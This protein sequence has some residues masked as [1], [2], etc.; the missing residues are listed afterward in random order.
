MR[1]LRPQNAFDGYVAEA[2]RA[3]REVLV[4]HD[5]LGLSQDEIHAASAALSSRSSPA[6]PRDIRFQAAVTRLSQKGTS[7]EAARAALQE[8]MNAEQECDQALWERDCHRRVCL[9]HKGLRLP[10]P[11]AHGPAAKPKL[12]AGH[13]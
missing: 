10:H 3:Y 12:P 7:A 2:F 8:L 13:R 11:D 6:Q 1:V 4:R 9:A 5:L